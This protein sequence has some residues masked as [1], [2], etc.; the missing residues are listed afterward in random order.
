MDLFRALEDPDLRLG[1]QINMFSSISRSFLSW[2]RAKVHSQTGWGVMAGFSTR[3]ATGFEHFKTNHDPQVFNLQGFPLWRRASK[4]QVL[5]RTSY[6]ARC[7]YNRLISCHTLYCL[8][9]S[10]V[11]WSC[12]ACSVVPCSVVTCSVSTC[13]FVTCSFATWFN[14]SVP[15]PCVLFQPASLWYWE[16]WFAIVELEKVHC[17]VI[18]LIDLEHTIS[19][20]FNIPGMVRR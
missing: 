7:K 12:A 11:T 2:R 15:K 19:T 1:D 20:I 8:A 10:F 18:S 3:S 16:I 5:L 14:F 6:I 17:S 13:S 4:I 9:C